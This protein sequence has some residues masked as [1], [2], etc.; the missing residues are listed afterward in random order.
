AMRA[1]APPVRLILR[2]WRPSDLQGAALVVCCLNENRP[3]RVRTAARAA[4]AIFHLMGAPESSDVTLGGVAAAGAL[5]LGVA[6]P[7]APWSVT[8]AVRARLERALP[9]GLA[10]FLEAATRVRGEAGRRIPDDETR[11]QFWSE[12]CEQAF[13]MAPRKAGEWETWLRQRLAE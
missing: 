2:R 3:S 10:D 4:Q 9:A 1:L 5:A 7:G 12:T 13:A 6:A 8:Q 11:A